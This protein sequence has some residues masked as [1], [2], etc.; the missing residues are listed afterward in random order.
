MW[1][2]PESLTQKACFY[3]SFAFLTPTV[4]D[5]PLAEDSVMF[6]LCHLVSGRFYFGK[7]VYALP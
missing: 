6:N 2:I 3:C 7:M 5:F 1:G 4:P